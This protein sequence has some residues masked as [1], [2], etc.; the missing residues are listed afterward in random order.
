[1]QHDLKEEGA[2]LTGAASGI[3][4]AI[5][6]AFIEVIQACSFMQ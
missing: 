2:V 5:A 4:K 1:M 6:T 3:C